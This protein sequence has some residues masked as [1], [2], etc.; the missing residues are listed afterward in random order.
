MNQPQTPE[1][2]GSRYKFLGYGLLSI[3]VITAVAYCNTL[4]IPLYLDDQ[5]NLITNPA[6]RDIGEAFSK[7]LAPRGVTVFTFACNYVFSNAN[8]ST[9]HLVNILIHMGAGG[10]SL[11]LLRRIFPDRLC[12]ALFGALLFVVHPLQT[13]AVNY[14]VQRMTVLSAFFSLLALYLFIRGREALAVGMTFRDS[15]HLGW[16]LGAIVAG[17]LA[18]FSKENAVVLPLL[19]LLFEKLFPSKPEQGWRPLLIYI[20]PFL[21][22]P[23]VA[24]AVY[25]FLPLLTGKTLVNYAKL[26]SLEGNTP[27]RYLLTQFSVLWIYIRLLFLPYGQALEYSYPIT[28]ALEVKTLAGVLGLVGILGLAWR[29]GRRQPV[30]AFGILWFFIAISVE[31]SII[32]LDPVNEHRLY[33]PMFGFVALLAALLGNIRMFRVQLTVMG[34]IILTMAG[35]TLQRNALWNDSIAFYRDNLVQWPQSERAHIA[36][37]SRLIKAGNMTEGEAILKRG[38]ELSPRLPTGYFALKE[39]YLEA[40]RIDEAIEVLKTGIRFRPDYAAYYND[41]AFLYT[42]KGNLDLAISLLKKSIELDPGVAAA[43][44]NLAQMQMVMGDLPQTESLLRKSL[45]LDNR[46]ADAHELLA[47]ILLTQERVSEATQESDFAAKL[48]IIKQ[49]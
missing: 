41:L 5:S 6:A 24:A 36:L 38:L 1:M 23:V 32:P 4:N 14:T 39:V 42:R 44:F 7:M 34:L 8:L 33:L 30:M 22:V 45:Q 9:Y 17:G 48:R 21:L 25:Y 2:S 15:R 31:S 37:G 18:V 29:W 19:L 11:L 49:K 46:N 27:F 47:N 3:V 43:Y 26:D 40:G 10:L 12:L 28:K 20:A 13:Q 35:L 16:Y